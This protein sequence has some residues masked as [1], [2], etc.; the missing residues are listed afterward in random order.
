LG[1]IFAIFATQNT[2]SVSLNFGDY[3]LNN[4]PTY[5]VV[6]TPLLIGL[7]LALLFHIAR[8]LSQKLTI[9]EQKDDIRNLKKQLAEV[10]KIAHKYQL[11]STK[12]KSENG[13]PVDEDSI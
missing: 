6:L 12:L 10:T 8:D 7:A 3:V 11:E 4:I 5:L 1:V 9:N 2:G 13:S